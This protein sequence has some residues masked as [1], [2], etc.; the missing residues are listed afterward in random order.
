AG[1]AYIDEQG[2]VVVETAGQWLHE[3]RRQIAAMLQLPEEQVVVRYAAIGGAFG[4]REDLS[5]QHLLALA[6]WKLNRTVAL[7]WSREES[8]IGHNKRHPFS[9][10]CRWGARRDGTI[11]AVEAEVLADGGAYASTSVEVTKVATLFAN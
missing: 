5:I 7:V 8:M 3:D 1:I 9:I 10:R 6:A 4:G 2:R 11:T